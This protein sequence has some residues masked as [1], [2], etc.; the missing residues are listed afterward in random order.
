MQI[1]GKKPQ[2]HL[3]IVREWPNLPPILRN[4]DNFPHGTFYSTPLQ[5]GTKEYSAKMLP[6]PLDL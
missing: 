4:L 3:I 6:G 2:V 5:L 1:L